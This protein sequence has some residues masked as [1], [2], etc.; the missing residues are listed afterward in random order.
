[1]YAPPDFL[2]G[3]ENVAESRPQRHL[4]GTATTA[5]APTAAASFGMPR[6]VQGYLFK[7]GGGGG[8]GRKRWVTLI[9]PVLS[10]Y[11]YACP[12]GAFP[13]RGAPPQACAQ[14]VC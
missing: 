4:D 5:V 10:I 6:K 3:P 2:T 11:K 12:P 14:R 7:N 1:M 13:L 8:A 9:G